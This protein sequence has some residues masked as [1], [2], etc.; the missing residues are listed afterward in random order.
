MAN[1]LREAGVPSRNDE[2]AAKS[3]FVAAKYGSV[4]A[5]KKHLEA[6]VDVNG[7]NKNGHTALHFAASAGQVDAVAALIEAKADPALADKAK[8][9]ALH[10][11]VSNKRQATATLLLEKGAPV[12]ATDKN[13]K[14]PLD[15]AT[16]KAVPPSLNCSE[17]RAARR[18]GNWLQPTIFLLRPR[19]ATWRRSKNC[20]RPARM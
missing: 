6:G 8:R 3:I 16:G 17:A 10:Y 12:N 7:K 19:W 4:A 11:A 1:F 2:A 15:Y 13:G 9:T 18:S 14:T 5:I 20:L